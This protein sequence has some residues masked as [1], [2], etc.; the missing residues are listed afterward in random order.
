MATSSFDGK[1]VGTDLRL[2]MDPNNPKSF[3]TA[4]GG[5]EIFERAIGGTDYVIHMF[6]RPATSTFYPNINATSQVLVVGGGGGGGMD[7][8]GGGGGGGVIY[9]ASFSLNAGLS[10]SVTVGDGGYGGPAGGGGYRPDGVGPQPIGH[11]FTVSATSGQ[12]SVFSTATALITAGGGGYGGSSYWGYTPNQGYGANAT[13]GGSGGGAS[14]YKQENT[15]TPTNRAGTSTGGGYKGGEAN[16][17]GDYYSGGGG[18]AGGA[19][20]DG[21]AQPNGGPGVANSILGT[22]YYWGGGGGGGSY[23]LANGGNG[24]IGGGG[25]GGLGATIGGAAGGSSLYSAWNGAPGPN[26]AWA[27]ARG[28][29]GAPNSGGGGGGG[30]H[31]RQTN[32]GGKGGSGIVIVRYPKNSTTQ[33]QY[34]ISN[35]V[36]NR[37]ITIVGTP[38]Y[39]SST[40]KYYQLNGTNQYLTIEDDSTLRPSSAVT[41]GVWAHLSNWNIATNC[42]FLSKTNNGG[43]QIGLNESG[44]YPGALGMLVYLNGV[45]YKVTTYTNLSAI[46][47][48]WHYVVGTCDGRYVR[49]YLDSVL[50]STFDHGSN[51]GLGYNET[52]NLVIGA[53]P[54]GG[55]AVSSGYFPG[56]IG[57]AHVNGTA[58]SQ[59]Q[60]SNIFNKTKATYGL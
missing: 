30:S 24:G 16:S 20:T 17:T 29:D 8:G 59:T 57:L 33:T 37:P 47:S 7:M 53:E 18:G 32:M 6:T 22:Q 26:G 35:S 39:S 10:A 46:S 12:N 23:R 27:D 41:I 40:P 51:V 36:T 49:L 31:Y 5:D 11:Q 38:T 13:N 45:G 15:W 21:P 50:L 4:Y 54:D 34:Y 42:R 25:G 14:G 44:F 19:G 3:T 1:F 60:I 43:W 58:L 55:S 2:L 48:G 28:G 56:R 52:N 9:N